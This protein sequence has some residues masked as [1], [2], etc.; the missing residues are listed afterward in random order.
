MSQLDDL[1]A[2]NCPDGVPHKKLGDIATLLRGNGMPKTMLTESG[3]GAIH[4]GQIYTRYGTSTAKTIS[5]VSEDDAKKLTKAAPGDIVIT[6]TSENLEDV[7]K[8]VAWL[9]RDQIVTGGHATVIKHDFDSRFLSYWFQTPD[10]YIQ[11]KKLATGTKV[12]DVSAKQLEK[13]I[14]PVPPLEIQRHIADILDTF[15]K[16]EAELEAEL[17]A[18][19]Q[20]YD[21]YRH[22]ELSFD[23]STPR[24][25]LG[26]IAEV[27][28]GWG[29][30]NAHQ[31]SP[32]G[33]IPFYKVSD[34]N[35]LGNE[36]TM[37]HANNFVTDEVARKLGV[38]PAPAGS[39]VFPKIGAAVAT[40]KK[41]ILSRP[42]AYDNNVMGLIPGERIIPRYLYHWMLTFDLSKL[43]ND[44][45]AVPS[46]R[47]SEAEQVQVPL[48]S[49]N[50]QKRIVA[51][52]DK[53]DALVNDL[54]IGLPAELAAR[55]QQYEYY[56]DKLLTFEELDPAS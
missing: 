43:A 14:V 46:I 45:G 51:I 33:N 25:S 4:Y 15:S 32:D 41:R 23:I 40:N 30:P 19:K 9:G 2:A 10:F 6:N 18:R 3:V 38:K 54:S 7:G 36:T 52:L 55:R 44:S 8:A 20:Q 17:E 26:E 37:S 50:E 24:V 5:F 34:M 39:I 31:G 42:S 47:K 29:F 13:L 22:L 1:L 49:V 27:R 53:F 11:K 48:P 56:R 12:I 16:M 28:S 21:H 35:L